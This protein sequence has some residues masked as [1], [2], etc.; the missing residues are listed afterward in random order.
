MRVAGRLIPGL[1]LA[2]LLL[3]LGDSGSFG[4]PARK[5]F[6][7]TWQCVEYDTDYSLQCRSESTRCGSFCFYAVCVRCTDDYHE[8]CRTDCD[9]ENNCSTVCWDERHGISPCLD[10]DWY[11]H[12]PGLGRSVRSDDYETPDFSRLHGAGVGPPGPHSR[13]AALRHG[14]GRQ[15]G[16]SGSFVHRRAPSGAYDCEYG[17]NHG[18]ITSRGVSNPA[19]V[20]I[21]DLS[22]LP[23]TPRGFRCAVPPCCEQGY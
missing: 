4:G 7:N 9:A 1:A 12:D 23:L 22:H 13:S 11:L 16:Y 3:A 20:L 19:E 5:V 18:Y 15:Q 10:W 14:A 17:R 8:H 21:G 6:A 2:L